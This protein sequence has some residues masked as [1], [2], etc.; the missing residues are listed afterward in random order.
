MGWLGRPFGGGADKQANI[1]IFVIVVCLC[2]AALVFWR[3]D[4]TAHSDL[5]I[6]YITPFLSIVTLALGYIFGSNKKSD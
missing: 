3:V 5:V 4:P 1:A 2:V 6:K